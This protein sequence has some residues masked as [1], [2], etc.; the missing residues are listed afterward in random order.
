MIHIL[1]RTGIVDLLIPA[2]APT[3]QRPGHLQRGA[4]AALLDKADPR[5]RAEV[6]AQL[7]LRLT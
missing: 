2:G 6:Y 7:G 3:A 5:D 1:C 4:L